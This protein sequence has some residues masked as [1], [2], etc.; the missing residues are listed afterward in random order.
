MQNPAHR[1]FAHD[2][3]GIGLQASG[4]LFQSQ[5]RLFQQPL[6]QL[7]SATIIKQYMSSRLISLANQLAAATTIVAQQRFNKEPADIENVC[8]PALRLGCAFARLHDLPT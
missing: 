4:Q 8:Q 2:H 3:A 1:G 5:I 7:F 6:P